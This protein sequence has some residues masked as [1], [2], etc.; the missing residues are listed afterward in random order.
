MYGE[1]VFYSWQQWEQY[2]ATKTYEN[3]RHHAVEWK[4]EFAIIV[5]KYNWSYNI[6][7]YN[8]IWNFIMYV[9][10]NLHIFVP[11]ADQIKHIDVLFR[12]GYK[13]NQHWHVGIRNNTL[14]YLER[15]VGKSISVSKIR[16]DYLRDYQCVRRSILLG[17][18][19]RIDAFPFFNDTPVWRPEDLISDSHWPVI[20]QDALWLRN[21][22]LTEAGLGSLATSVVDG[23]EQFEHIRLPPRRVGFLERSPRSK[24]RLTPSGKMWLE[25]TLEELCKKH[26]MEYKHIRT[27]GAMS[28]KEQVNQLQSIGLAVGIHGANMV[29]T[30]FM[31]TAGALFEIFPWRYVRYYY[32]SGSNSGLR[33]SFHEPERGYDRNCS[34]T[35]PTCF[36][37]Y[38]ESVIYLTESDREVIHKRL[39]S[40]IMYITGLHRLFPDGVIPLRKE[41]HLYQFG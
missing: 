2:V 17:R 32:A 33:Y 39:E 21:A 40:A 19:A 41:G 16:Y 3:P 29:N 28:F 31:P 9:I 36:M 18:E 35:S 30:V 24:R 38:R 10:R 13:Y 6:C 34:F 26:G 7:H 37:K 11:D 5:P 20:P 22:V 15:Q 25:N 23:V 8:R 4:S 1:E 14:P 27:S 12:S